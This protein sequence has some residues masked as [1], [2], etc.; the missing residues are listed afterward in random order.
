MEWSVVWC[1]V[2]WC[3]ECSVVE[4]WSGVVGSGQCSVVE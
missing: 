1:G 2:V 4:E 3:S